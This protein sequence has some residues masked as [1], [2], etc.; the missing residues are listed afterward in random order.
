[1]KLDGRRNGSRKPFMDPKIPDPKARLRDYKNQVADFSWLPEVNKVLGEDVGPVKAE[2]LGPNPSYFAGARC[3][4]GEGILVS[5]DLGT[6]RSDSIVAQFVPPFREGLECPQALAHRVALEAN[7]EENFNFVITAV[8][9]DKQ[10]KREVILGPADMETD[11]YVEP[12][13]EIRIS[14]LCCGSDLEDEKV[15]TKSAQTSFPAADQDFGYMYPLLENYEDLKKNYELPLPVPI[16]YPS[17]L[18][19]GSEAGGISGIACTGCRFL[20]YPTQENKN[21]SA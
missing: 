1:M 8:S 15:S 17:S 3:H 16:G 9:Y 13:I 20:F 5:R 12:G 4:L 18:K 21:G 14:N 19:V 6:L 2:C 10:K 7:V 11:D